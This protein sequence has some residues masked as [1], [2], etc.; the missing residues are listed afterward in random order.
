MTIADLMEKRA[1]GIFMD[2]PV[3]KCDLIAMDA[4]DGKILFD[5]YRNKKETIAKYS[6]GK[7]ISL[8]ADCR[9]I[10]GVGFGDYFKAVMKCYVSHDSWKE[11]QDGCDA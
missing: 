3:L 1:D 9:H 4:M 11:E 5:T 10:R 2:N 7:V 6:S 8:W